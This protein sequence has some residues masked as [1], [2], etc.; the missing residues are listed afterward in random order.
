MHRPFL[1]FGL[2]TILA[3]AALAHS[4]VKNPAVKVRMAL[5]DDIKNATGTLGKMVK[6]ELSFDPGQAEA[7][8]MVL[9][10]A[11]E[12]IPEAFSAPETDPKSEALPAIWD[13]WDRF[14]A[15]SD[16]M[17]RAALDMNT[18]SLDGIRAGIGALGKAAGTATQ[19]FGS[20]T[21]GSILNRTRCVQSHP[22]R[23]QT[24][25]SGRVCNLVSPHC[26]EK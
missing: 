10:S 6:G 17:G 3:S 22:F 11:A 9:I 13:Q 12:Q 23:S 8:Q 16:T 25:P 7:A 18:A 21:D 1:A 26:S 4:G 5:M 20:K 2:I 24:R 15:D 14:V 19:H